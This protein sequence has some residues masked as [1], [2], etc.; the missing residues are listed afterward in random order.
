VH[1]C[2]LGAGGLGSVIGARLA[3]SG[4]QVSL[5]ARPAH[6]AAIREH[7][8]RVAGISG[9]RTVR[10]NLCAFEAI[11]EV[12]GHIDWLAVLVKTR[13]TDA[14]LD[15]AKSHIA[16]IGAA[17]S[18]QNS[19]TKDRSL[20]ERL[21]SANV[22]G[23]S[24][25]EAGVLVAPGSVRHTATAPTAFYFGE[26]PVAGGGASERVTA[27]VDVFTRAGLAAQ[28][29]DRIEQVQWEK[30][31]QISAVAGFCASTLGFMPDASFAPALAV[32]PGAEHYV[33]LVTE[34]LA[35]YQAL[36]YEPQDFYAPFA[37]FRR[38]ATRSFDEAVAD[39]MALGATMVANGVG[40]RPSLHE[41]LLRHRPTEVDDCI[42]EYLRAADRLGISTPTL[43]GAHRVISTLELLTKDAT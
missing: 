29:T 31:L 28:A 20:S 1:L 4:V 39:A 23:A 13:D 15:G 12:P 11:D 7:G 8:L 14:A 30:L 2:V 22:V 26:L 37:T 24:T 36:G 40:G 34:L 32:R 10:D 33:Q 18:L 19:V 16:R 6:V 27:L 21:G 17:F 38:A 42:G 41:D 25:T 5:V 35:V 3:E 43:R 9:T